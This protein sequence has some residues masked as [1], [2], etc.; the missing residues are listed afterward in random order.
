MVILFLY[1]FGNTSP[2]PA[3]PISDP[4]FQLANPRNPRLRQRH[5]QQGFTGLQ[6]LMGSFR[7]EA[8]ITQGQVPLTFEG[9]KEVA[10]FAFFLV[11]TRVKEP[12]SM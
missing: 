6:L 8:Q 9:S 1:E 10:M 4:N 12:F 5:L 2:K 11:G 7:S 3:T